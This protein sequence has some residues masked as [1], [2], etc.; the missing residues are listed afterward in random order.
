MMMKMNLED[1]MG[2]TRRRY[3]KG[4]IVKRGDEIFEKK[5]KSLLK[6][7]DA[8]DYVVIDIE[9]EDYEVDADNLA[10]CKR[11]RERVPDAQ[12]YAR[13]VGSRYLHHFGGRRPKEGTAT[14]GDAIYEDKVRP[15]LKKADRGKFVAIDVK[16]GEYEIAAD[17]LIACDRLESRVPKPQTWL[18]RIGSKYLFSF[19]GHASEEST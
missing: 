19:G 9:T 3:P 18:I 8:L 15:N 14:R 5:I 13:R 12:I 1:N 10:A 7:R 17:P 16:T 11:L 6:G 2:A 4:E